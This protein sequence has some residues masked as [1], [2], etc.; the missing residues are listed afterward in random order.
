MLWTVADWR[1][2]SR[3]LSPKGKKSVFT[4]ASTMVLTEQPEL[5]VSKGPPGINE[6]EVLRFGSK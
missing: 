3:K 6:Y 5:H 4:F 2:L 1:S